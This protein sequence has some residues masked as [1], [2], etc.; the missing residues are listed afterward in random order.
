M[1]ILR[2]LTTQLHAQNGQIVRG[3][4]IVRIM[5]AIWVCKMRTAHT[6][7]LRFCIH[8]LHE[9]RFRTTNGFCNSNRH[10]IGGL[11]QHDLERSVERHY[12]ARA[13]AHLARR[14]FRGIDGHFHWRFK[15]HLTRLK[16]AERDIS[17]HHLGQR[18]RIPALERVLRGINLTGGHID[19]NRW[20]S[21]SSRQGQGRKSRC[22]AQDFQRLRD[23]S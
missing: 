23:H 11:Y 14:L 21:Q 9:S 18:S 2:E 12:G 7:A 22:C 17:G 20:I 1:G 6:D 16:R 13:I 15:R 8:A 10:V 3:R 19:S 4:I 5:Q